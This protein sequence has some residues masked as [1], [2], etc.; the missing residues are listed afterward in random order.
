MSI[1][2]RSQLFYDG[3]FNTRQLTPNK[4]YQK[5]PKSV[6]EHMISNE[7]E[8]PFIKLES[9]RKLKQGIVEGVQKLQQNATVCSLL[10]SAAS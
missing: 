9:S 2:S 7:H 6:A 4:A 10:A 3:N 5:S 1:L 8:Q